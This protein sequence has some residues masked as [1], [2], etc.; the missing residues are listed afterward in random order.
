LAGIG[1]PISMPGRSV[2]G[3]EAVLALGRRR[4]RRGEAGQRRWCRPANTGPGDGGEPCVSRAAGY[5]PAVRHHYTRCTPQVKLRCRPRGPPK[6][7]LWT[8]WTIPRRWTP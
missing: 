3:T 7:R 1:K 2:E 8:V 4:R 6:G 5:T